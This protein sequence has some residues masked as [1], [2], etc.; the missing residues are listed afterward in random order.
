M[1][2]KVAQTIAEIDLSELNIPVINIYGPNQIEYPGKYVARIFDLEKPTNTVVVK[3]SYEELQQD[4]MD[5]KPYQIMGRFIER[6]IVDP[7]SYIGVW[8]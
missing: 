3:D 5:N 7:T 4:I 1:Q 8:V 6:T 2:D